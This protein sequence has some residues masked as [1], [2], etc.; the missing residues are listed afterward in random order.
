MKEATKT[1]LIDTLGL[2]FV[3]W[4]VGYAASIILFFFIPKDILGWVLFV[5]FTPLLLYMPYRRFNK[6]KERIG[7]YL[8]VAAVWTIIAVVFDYLF[9]VKLFN[10]QDY[11]KLD[12]YVYYTSTF[13]APL[14]IGAKYGTGRRR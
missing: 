6:R 14:L 8:L 5:I 10:A 13:L 2:G 11:Y 1:K 3:I 12:V 7:H 9:I 4:L